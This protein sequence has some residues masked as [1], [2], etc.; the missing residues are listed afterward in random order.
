MV[1]SNLIT[2]KFTEKEKNILY[3]NIPIQKQEYDINWETYLFII[4]NI[5]FS[6]LVFK[7]LIFDYNPFLKEKTFSLWIAIIYILIVIILVFIAPYLMT[8]FILALIRDIIVYSRYS[9]Y[10]VEYAFEI[11]EIEIF[12]GNEDEDFVIQ[13]FNAEGENIEIKIDLKISVEYSV[14]EDFLKEIGS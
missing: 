12:Q 13:L 9:R 10:A 4:L 14:K 11:T 7:A 6:I 5:T 8:V 2:R 1:K 3:Q